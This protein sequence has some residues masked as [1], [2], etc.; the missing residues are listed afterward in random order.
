MEQRQKAVMMAA[1]A[2]YTAAIDSGQANG[3]PLWSACLK[4]AW[5][6]DQA[7]VV[8]PSF[9]V[10]HSWAEQAKIEAANLRRLEA[11][12]S[13]QPLC[14][15]QPVYRAVE[16]ESKAVAIDAAVSGHRHR[17]TSSWSQ[18]GIESVRSAFKAS[19]KLRELRGITLD[20]EKYRGFAEKT[21]NQDQQTLDVS[22]DMQRADFKGFHGKF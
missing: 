5:A 10:A 16:V 9:V 18:R 6:S 14:K 11:I 3:M 13:G 21:R 12:R 20:G 22:G 15:K 8:A 17:L 2:A 19:H 7:C 4:Q 1:H